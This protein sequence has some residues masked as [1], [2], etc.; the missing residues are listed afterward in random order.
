V[1]GLAAARE[2]EDSSHTG[3]AILYIT[4]DHPEMRPVPRQFVEQG[5]TL[6]EHGLSKEVLT[7]AHGLAK[8]LVLDQV[9]EDFKA[10]YL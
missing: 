7:A 1:S 8:T 4:R 3:L 9:I 10:R 5:I 6:L 2:H